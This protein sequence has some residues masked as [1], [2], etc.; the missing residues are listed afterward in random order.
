MNE[1]LENV[2]CPLCG[3]PDHKLLFL[4]R[5]H[6][7][8]VSDEKFRVV[9]CRDCGFVFVNPRPGAEDIHAYYP[10]EFYAGHLSP[11]ELL[12]ETKDRNAAK[13]AMFRH[14]RPG[15]L[16]DIGCQKGEFLFK[17][18][19]AGWEVHGVEF[20]SKPPNLFG[21]PIYYGEI[22][23]A[24]YP[25]EHFDLITMWAVLEHVHD[26]LAVLCHIKRLLRPGGRALILVPNFNSIPARLMRHDDVPRHLLMFTPRTFGRLSEKAGFKVVRTVFGDDIFSGSTRGALNFLYKRLRGEPLE[27]ILA[28]N[29]EP[30]RWE[31]FSNRVHGEESDFM[32]KVD[33]L[34]IR[35]SPYLD[36]LMNWL[37]LGF[38][39]TAEIQPAR[40]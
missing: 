31:E 13:L 3:A 5:D 19:K 21:L 16:L 7:H 40:R 6:T 2:P 32:L 9:R 22:G 20:S 4:R 39:M 11:G 8:L 38:I 15:R 28:Q 35:L 18:G 10:Q 17:A 36:R 25:A 37:G 14:L 24:P 23:D 1:A 33:R 12:E 27:E 34:D 26:P 29:R 30:G